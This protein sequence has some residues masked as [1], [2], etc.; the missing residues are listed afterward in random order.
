MLVQL[1][2]LSGL[3]VPDGTAPGNWQLNDDDWTIQSGNPW[4]GAI[5]ALVGGLE[6]GFYDFPCIGNHHP[7]WRTHIFQLGRYTTNQSHFGVPESTMD[8]NPEMAGSGIRPVAG[9]WWM[10]M[11]AKLWRQGRMPCKAFARL[12][13]LGRNI[14]WMVI[15][16]P[17]SGTLW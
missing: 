7:N 2:H 6:H 12:R 3:P 13:G 11:W 17:L 10:S 14:W 4:V 9:R 5:L 8:W 16:S 1:G 15:E